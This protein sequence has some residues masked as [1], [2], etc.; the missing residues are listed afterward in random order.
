MSNSYDDPLS[1]KV[2]YLTDGNI[3]ASLIR[4][5]LM[6]SND[7]CIR[8]KVYGEPIGCKLHKATIEHK[9]RLNY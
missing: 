2:N 1:S 7:S 9:K 8:L 5:W 6:P 4:I 3:T